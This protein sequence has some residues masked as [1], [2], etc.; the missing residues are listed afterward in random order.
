[1]YQHLMVPLDDS[2]LATVT[3][4]HA[5]RFANTVGARITFFH[6]AADLAAT[7]DGALLHI[8]DGGAFADAQ[9]A[10][11]QTELLKART[12]ADLAGVACETLVRTAD[13]PAR[14]I[15]ETALAQGCDLIFLSAHG[16]T[17]IWHGVALRLLEITQLPVLVASVESNQNDADMNR[18]LGII[19]AEHRSIA[20]VLH[21]MQK[22]VR[23]AYE[24]GLGLDTAL[25]QQMI[26]Y[27]RNFPAKLHHPKEEDQLFRL[28]RLRSGEPEAV[29]QELEREHAL[30]AT[31]VQAV[32][33]ALARHDP[34][35]A[36]TLEPVWNA[37][38]RLAGAQWDHMGIEESQV[39]TAAAR[40]L[41]P[42]D[43][44]AVTQAFT[45]NVD[46]L[47]DVDVGRPLNAAL[48]RISATLLAAPPRP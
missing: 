13:S 34:V 11:G 24:S 14:A 46:P 9:V 25:L 32:A 43:W 18:A 5:V 19:S 40:H 4:A 10:Q 45:A 26:E 29:L 28:L 3:V 38:Q 39:F 22:T 7:G 48:A 21:G 12:A 8:L 1:M 47:R 30:E 15:H 33:D 6:A 20:A 17:P 44:S 31:L 36:S 41:L 23:E 16:C 37:V 27:L 2:P 42:E 35:D